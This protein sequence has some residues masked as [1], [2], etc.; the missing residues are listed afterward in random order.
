MH[1]N[2]VC[3]RFSP[4]HTTFEI[5]TAGELKDTKLSTACSL[6]T[7]SGST[8]SSTSSLRRRRLMEIAEEEEE[9]ER[10]RNRQSVVQEEKGDGQG[11]NTNPPAPSSP[12]ARVVDRQQIA[13]PQD[14]GFSS[15][16]EPASYESPASPARSGRRVSSQLPRPELYGHSTYTY[17][18]PKVKLAPRPSLETKQRPSTSGTYRP[19]AALPAGYKVPSKG[20]KKTKS[21]D[22]IEAD[23]PDAPEHTHAAAPIPE[24]PQESEHDAAHLLASRPATSSGASVRSLPGVASSLSDKTKMT[25]EKARLMKAMK[26]REKK[27]MSMIVPEPS[28]ALEA[29]KTVGEPV[30]EEEEHDEVVTDTV[31]RDVP[32]RLSISK[33]EAALGVGPPT[34]VTINTDTNTEYTFSDSHPPS[35]TLASSEIGDSTKAS[36]LSESTDETVH[37]TVKA[38]EQDADDKQAED[39][40][41]D[42]N[43]CGAEAETYRD[44][45]ITA[46]HATGDQYPT[47]PEKVEPSTPSSKGQVV[48]PTK[49]TKEQPEIISQ[50]VE[51]PLKDEDFSPKSPWGIP[52][53]KFSSGEG[54]SPSSPTLNSQVP[55]QDL[56]APPEVVVAPPLTTPRTVEAAASQS[57]AAS[58]S[59]PDV[60]V[61][62]EVVSSPKSLKA[63]RKTVIDPIRTLARGNHRSAPSDPLLDD[64]LLD[65]LQ[66][67]TLQEA[68]PMVVSKS[69][70]TPVFPSTSPRKSS[71][72]P[73]KPSI[74]PG[75]PDKPKNTPVSRS[76]STPLRGPLLVPKDVTA[77]S[78]RS[79]SA[80]GAAFMHNL[81]RQASNPNALQ[82]KKTGNLGSS[83]S[84]R[85]KA[86]EQLNGG[87]NAN[88]AGTTNNDSLRPVSSRSMGAPSAAFYNVRKSSI[89][90]PS[91]SSLASRPTSKNGRV[92]PAPDQITPDDSREASPE[93]GS[94][95]AKRERSGSVASR[96][97]VFE[98]APSPVPAPGLSPSPTPRGRPESVQVTAR[99]VR[100][101][102]QSCPKRPVSHNDPA[103]YDAGDLKPSH[104][105]VDHQR[106]EPAPTPL[107][108]ALPIHAPKPGGAQERRESHD[109]N[110]EPEE[111][112]DPR[113]RSSLNMVKDF[114]KDRRNSIS[115]SR[116]PSSDNLA[117]TTPMS[118]KSPSRPPSV[119]QNS[120]GSASLVHRLSISSH[121]SFSR[122]R[123]GA[124]P[125]RS[126]S[127]LTDH[128]SETDETGSN[129]RSKSRTSRFMRRLSNSLGTGRKANTPNISPTVAEED[130]A[131]AVASKPAS[132][133]PAGSV[134]TVATYMGDVNVQFPDNLLWKRRSMCLDSAGFLVLSAVQGNKIT[135]SK[136]TAVGLKRYH[137]SDFRLPYIP[138]V[139]VQELPNSVVLDFKLGSGLQIACEDRAGQMSTLNGTCYT[140]SPP[141]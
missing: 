133:N 18:K 141:E 59:S 25:P 87:N 4:Y 92:T 12:E 54:K 123:D 115:N 84:Q 41:G 75:K 120:S 48:E 121:R 97:S 68:Q 14:P 72:S 117:V 15:T 1:F 65:E 114:I 61:I 9:G 2:A 102:S 127:S 81:T 38:G 64:A 56:T 16:P 44:G 80:G 34:P 91:P 98:T 106:A 24:L 5:A 13:D 19:T 129:K 78:A 26:L 66:A 138:D 99:I 86:L 11:L 63:K 126:P 112:V 116:P 107:A 77:S 76:V 33:S 60:P 124:S 134:S 67:A 89:R 82:P 110:A 36:S 23:G 118:S 28:P 74:S 52:L 135:T 55:A 47:I 139:E 79:V 35:P 7:A 29:L 57:S 42:G 125:V 43:E 101:G 45:D 22:R 93:A 17:G 46:P 8:S 130:D 58:K 49:Q 37:P 131:P 39:E 100:D 132:H 31:A 51:A 32:V 50:E 104:L 62:A 71:A 103:E 88:N 108:E 83:I 53:S 128:G 69:P 140:Y 119:Q 6:H 90:D 3:E 105:V 109:T 113:R 85:I 70:I 96:L 20:H 95:A 136:D 21:G 122:E 30:E 137:L 10:E 73:S 111:G 27:K 94:I 40:V